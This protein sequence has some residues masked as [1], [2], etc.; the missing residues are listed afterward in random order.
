MVWIYVYDL[1]YVV[2]FIF[3]SC[4]QS[5]TEK[6]KSKATRPVENTPAVKSSQLS[7][8]LQSVNRS[9]SGKLDTQKH[10]SQGKLLVLKPSKD[11]SMTTAKPEGSNGNAIISTAVAV[12]AAHGISQLKKPHDVREASQQPGIPALRFKDSLDQDKRSSIQAQNRSE[13][14]NTLRKKSTSKSESAV[15]TNSDMM[16]VSHGT[17][18]ENGGGD[19]LTVEFV[20][21]IHSDGDREGLTVRMNESP[22]PDSSEK[23]AD[24]MQVLDSEE[25]E[26][27]FM[28]SLGWEEN[29]EGSEL[30]EEEINAFY[31]VIY[32]KINFSSNFG[33]LHS[34][35]GLWD[36]ILI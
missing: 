16:T 11:G 18:E 4:V 17:E 8:S 3:T 34:T 21:E 25:E 36:P 23:E 2:L 24:N 12:S 26:A 14:F 7:G 32:V 20:P 6:S 35:A 22:E 31:Q 19:P 5:L 29:A 13:F 30:T 10:S 15:Q 9:S 33:F 27:A 1:S 28:R